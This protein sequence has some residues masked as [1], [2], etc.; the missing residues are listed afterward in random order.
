MRKSILPHRKLTAVLMILIMGM[1][2]VSCKMFNAELEQEVTSE[3]DNLI[4]VGYSQLGS[5]SV[6]RTANTN[7]IQKALSEENGFFLQLKNARQKQENQI[8]AIRSFISQRVDYIVFSPIEEEGWRTVL[9]E[10]RKAGIPVILVDRTISTKDESLYTTRVGTDTYWEGEQA[11]IWLEEDLLKTGEQD[12]T[13]NIVILEGTTGATSQIGR[14]VGFENIAKQHENWNILASESGDFTTAKGKE[15]MEKYLWL[16]DDIDVL[17]SQNDDM[18]FGAI[19]ALKESGRYIGPEDD[20]RIISF[21]AGRSAL[22]LVKAG[23]IDVDIECNPEQGELLAEVIHKLQSGEKV[24]KVYMVE[25]KVFTID[26]VDE[27][28]ESRTY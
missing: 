10:A 28:L 23:E 21:D 16:Y 7:S 5:E 2:C 26:N 19:E 24:E 3:E 12:E 13:V 27:Y 6:W 11:G 17:V 15:V 9:T 25:D 22:E 1:S 8:K 14:S 18:T 20:I 4:V